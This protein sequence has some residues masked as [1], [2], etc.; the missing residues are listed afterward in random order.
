MTENLNVSRFRN[1]EIIQE[2]QGK[3]EWEDAGRKHQAAWCYYENSI[4]NGKIFGKLYNWFAVNDPRGLAPVGYKIA[5]SNDWLKLKEFIQNNKNIFSSLNGG[6]RHS[7]R[8]RGQI[9]ASKG[10]LAN[11]W[12]F[13]RNVHFVQCVSYD[14]YV[15]Q[16]TPIDNLNNISEHIASKILSS[17]SYVRCI[18]E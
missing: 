14:I 6:D 3:D 5:S 12:C 13:G 7:D 11:F 8:N 10:E 4:E 9:F 16:L 18:K 1:G 2:V 17:G 15:L